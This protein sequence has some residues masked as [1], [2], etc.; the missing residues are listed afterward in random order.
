MMNDDDDDFEVETI[1]NILS[2]SYLFH[3]YS[4]MKFDLFIPSDVK[5][6]GV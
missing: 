2:V 4:T 6:I 3:K 5:Y 1:Q